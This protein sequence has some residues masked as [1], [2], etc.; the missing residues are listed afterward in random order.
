M[1]CISCLGRSTSVLTVP[2]QVLGPQSQVP[3]A[4]RSRSTARMMF[5]HYLLVFSEDF[6]VFP[7]VSPT[8]ASGCNVCGEIHQ[9][10]FLCNVF[11]VPCTAVR[12]FRTNVLASGNRINL[13][14][15]PAQQPR[16]PR[17]NCLS[18]SFKPEFV[19]CRCKRVL[20]LS[21]W[22]GIYNWPFQE[23]SAGWTP[24]RAEYHISRRNQFSTQQT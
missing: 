11:C 12:S 5:L 7:P 10:Q 8:V 19:R 13:E 24:P 16:S 20:E 2:L 23:I 15:L 22:Q 6:F 17:F 4:V 21:E 3:H 9:P 1:R 14:L 18:V